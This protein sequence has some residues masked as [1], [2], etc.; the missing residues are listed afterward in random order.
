MY[1]N[2]KKVKENIVCMLRKVSH[3]SRILSMA[4]MA[5]QPFH[6]LQAFYMDLIYESIVDFPYVELSITSVWL[7]W[8]CF[9]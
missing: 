4:C 6:S 9:R 8:T 3:F 1:K 2:V 5:R 7:K